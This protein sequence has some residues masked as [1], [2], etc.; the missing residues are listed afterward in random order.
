MKSIGKFLAPL[1]LILALL[2]APAT[3]AEV[4][5]NFASTAEVK[6]DSTLVV[7]EDITVRVEGREIR[8]GIYRDFPTKYTSPS[9]KG[10]T[11]GFS[12]KETLLDGEKVPFSTE[13]ASNGVRVK[14]GDPDS[15]APLGVHTYSILYTTTGQIGFFEDHDELYWNVT[16]NG[17]IFPIEHAVFSLSLPNKTPFT[18]VDVYTGVQGAKGRDARVLPD[19]RA[20]TTS[21]LAPREGFTVAYTWP[22][23]IVT[24]PKP[25]LRYTF[26]SRYGYLFFWGA[27]LLL[28]VYYVAAWLRWGK[29]PPKRSIIPLFAPSEGHSPGFLRYV[30]RMEMDNAC[31][32]AE[33]LNLAVKGFITIEEMTLDEAMQRLGQIGETGLVKGMMSLASK[34]AGK[35]YSLHLVRNRLREK[36]TSKEEALLIST[37]FADSRDE[38]LLQQGNH[39]I[40]Q[41]ARS[42]LEALYKKGA[43][44]LFSKNT[45]PWL[46]GFLIP[47]ALWLLMAWGG[48]VETA[49]VSGVATVSLLVTGEIFLSIWRTLREKGRFFRKLLG[50]LIPVLIS[51]G[52]AAIFLFWLTEANISM[53]I[54]P[55]TIAGL[56]ILFRRLMTVRTLRGNDVLLEAEGLA[57][58]MNTA[59]RHRLE[60]FNPPE[61][62][63]EVFERLLPY[64]YALDTAETWANRF[65]DVLRRQEYSPGWYTGSSMTAFYTGS[66]VAAMTSSMASSI[67]SASASPGSSSGSGGGGSSG[68]GGGGGGGGG[69]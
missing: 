63:P 46:V 66:A 57:L 42:Q 20:E 23:G 49:V 16:G 2:A 28:L 67:S 35:R 43:K 50:L 11:V 52:I 38:L 45:F 56:V 21:V 41:S 18:S 59:E 61:E 53:L 3:G 15:S 62:T 30:R 27:P 25:P 60:M 24:P 44:P 36:T 58:Y 69:W 34:L 32:T 33:I 22:K 26:F 5:T 65:E 64:A 13:S 12:V 51:A 17:W 29:D 14:I 48:Q 4:I 40:L 55:F 39:A 10:I 7:R 6:E 19:R 9:G 31:F 47:A 1:C 68:G 54:P 37:L 8:K